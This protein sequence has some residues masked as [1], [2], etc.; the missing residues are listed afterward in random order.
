MLPILTTPVRWLSALS[1][2]ALSLAAQAAPV[3]VSVTIENLARADS[4]GFAP[5][6]VGFGNGTFD[7]FNEGQTPT[8][9]IISVAEGGSGSAWQPAFE[10][11]E[12]LATRGVIG[13]PLLSGQTRTQ[14]FLVDPAVNRYFTFAAMVIPSN[15][16]FIGNDS[17]LEHRLF[18]AAGDLQINAITVKARDIWNAGS[19][20]FS[21]AGAAFLVNGSNPVRSDEG[22]VVRFNFSEL[23]GFNGQTT[24]AGYVFNSNLAG[25][26]DIY[27]ISF[28][29]SAVPEPQSLALTAMGLLTMLGLQRRR[30][31]SVTKA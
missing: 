6:H 5:L 26:D 14:T 15:D 28:Q 19:E 3:Q 9:P 2:S 25:S 8:A 29:T 12:P 7:A 18:N 16:F 17:P 21:V 27:R 13:G 30:G 1:L 11:A 20:A 23:A 4:I 31:K 10:A 24:A 22:G